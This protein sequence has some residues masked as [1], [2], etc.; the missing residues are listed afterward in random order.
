MN[1]SPLA[2][3]A[4]SNL[5]NSLQRICQN[6]SDLLNA[7]DADV[8]SFERLLIQ[9]TSSIDETSSAS[10]NIEDDDND[11]DQN[12]EINEDFYEKLCDDQLEPRRARVTTL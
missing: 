2:T 4:V 7:L 12:R 9:I 3:D 8:G 5:L 1:N 10:S 11:N 6:L